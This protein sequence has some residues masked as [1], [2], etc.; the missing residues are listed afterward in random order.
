[1]NAALALSVLLVFSPVRAKKADERAEGLKLVRAARAWVGVPVRYDGRYKEISYP[2]GDPGGGVG[3]CSDLVVR[4]YRAIGLDLQVLVHLDIS[5]NL[6]AYPVEELYEQTRPDKNIDHRRVPNLMTFFRRKGN[7]LSVSYKGPDRKQWRPGDIVVFDLLGNGLP[8]HIGLV[9]DRTGPSG[10]P[11]V[12][13]HFPP[14]PSEDDCLDDWK[15]IGHFRYLPER[16][17][18]PD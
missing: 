2:G 13:H 9:S 3:V 5:Q 6:K 15:V 4:A 10:L 11:L 16:E 14:Y 12:I 8:S 18:R 1:M 17:S 7:V